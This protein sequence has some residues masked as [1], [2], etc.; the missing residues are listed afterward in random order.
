MQLASLNLMSQSDRDQASQGTDTTLPAS[1]SMADCSK[2][3]TTYKRRWG[4]SSDRVG[5]KSAD[6]RTR[7][8]DTSTLGFA[9]STEKRSPHM[10]YFHTD[11]SR[12]RSLSVIC[13]MTQVD[14]CV[15]GP[16]SKSTVLWPSHRASSTPGL[17]P[18]ALTNRAVRNFQRLSIPCS[19]GI[20]GLRFATHI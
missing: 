8:L 13:K 18:A 19:V 7:L 3:T 6:L 1:L 10:L 11:G 17:I 5:A 15:G 12:R 16:N 2:S 14:T 20:R 9:N 4:R